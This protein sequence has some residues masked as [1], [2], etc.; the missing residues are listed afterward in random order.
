L[1]LD[2]DM[3]VTS[4]IDKIFEDNQERIKTC[5]FPLFAKHPHNPFNQYSHII[6]NITNKVPKMKWVYSTYL[7]TREQKWFIQ[8]ALDYMINVPDNIHHLFYP[9]PEEG[10]LN[11]LLTKH[12]VDYDLGYNYFPNGLECVIDYYIDNT[13]E[14]GKQHI[15]NN[16]IDYDCPVKFYAFHGHAIKNVSYTKTVIERL[17]QL[18]IHKVNI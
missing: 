18:H 16:Y 11:A 14:E 1:L 7:F 4:D 6:Q 12:Q 15:Q 10:I 5:Q 17:K 9:V 2:G 8:E 13:N 3:I